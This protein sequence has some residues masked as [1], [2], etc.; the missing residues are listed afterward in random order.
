MRL[1]VSREYCD[2]RAAV[3]FSQARFGAGGVDV[4]VVAP[5]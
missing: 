1:L 2:L 4:R 3:T 5:G